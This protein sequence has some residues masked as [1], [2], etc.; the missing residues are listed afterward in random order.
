MS[1]TTETATIYQLFKTIT[2]TSYGVVETGTIA[3]A[4]VETITG[5]PAVTTSVGSYAVF[6]TTTINDS[7]QVITF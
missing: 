7:P 5:I 2:T 6:Q 3:S 4:L 1:T